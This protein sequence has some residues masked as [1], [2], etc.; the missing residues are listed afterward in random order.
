MKSVRI[1]LVDDFTP[2]RKWVRSKLQS[3]NHFEL[4][5]E[6]TSAIE[7]IQKTQELRPDVIVLDVTLPDKNGIETAKQLCRDVPSAKI[8][9]LS[10][11]AD[12]DIAQCALDSG[13]MGYV[14]KSEAE[15]ELL[16]ALEEI[17]RGGKFVGG[18]VRPYGR[19]RFSLNFCSAK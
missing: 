17:L 7:A 2:F 19:K 12:E 16:P 5:G 6:A 3:Q 15:G 13:A 11:H 10:R 4:I 9:F 18:G 14:V 1:L 8:L